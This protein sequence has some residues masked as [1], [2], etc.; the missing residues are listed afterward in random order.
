M[1]WTELA[2]KILLPATVLLVGCGAYVDK[3]A[4]TREQATE[5]AYPPI[6]QMLMVD[7][8]PVHA[9]VQGQGP[10]L[11]LIHGASG[12]ARD[13][14]F[15]FIDRLT[16]RYRVIVF[17]RPGLGYTGRI[18][19][20][21][22][23]PDGA[24]AETPSEQAIL[25]EAAARQLGV[26]NAIVLGQSY[27][28]AVA[29]AWGLERPDTAAALVL[30]SSVSTPWE[31]DLG[32]WYALMDSPL[33]PNVVAPLVSAFAPD[34]SADSVLEN[35]FTPQQPPE[36]YADYVGV[37]LTVRRETL[38]SNA[39]QVN[40]LLGYITQLQPYY[41]TYTLPIEAVHGDA[42]EVVPYALH[43]E[44]LEDRLS[45]LNMTKLQGIGHMPHHAAPGAVV[46]AIDRA[47]ARSGLR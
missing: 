28:G 35:I 34:S 12:N 3:R 31:T 7:G 27:G 44:G 29:L 41:E 13:F 19:A 9:V 47:A 38:I 18:D 4:D 36:G 20:A 45:T 32:G 25:L 1:T 14:T 37:G 40:S 21:V 46:A 30:V 15:D 17:D 33:G 16:D 43:A 5:E 42:D 6:G 22:N 26:K 8:T 23:N 24:R 2:L 10:D 39:N 11:V